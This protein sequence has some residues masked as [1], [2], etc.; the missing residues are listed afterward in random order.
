MQIFDLCIL[1]LYEILLAPL[2]AACQLHQLFFGFRNQYFSTR[3]TR[4]S[5]KDRSIKNGKTP[6]QDNLNAELFKVDPELAAEVRQPLFTS[7][8]EVKII[9]HFLLLKVFRFCLL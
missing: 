9:A 8:W 7:I 4:N 5:N 1:F 2:L 3:Q 6:G